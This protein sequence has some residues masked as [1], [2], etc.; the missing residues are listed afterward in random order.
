[1]ATVDYFRLEYNEQQGLFAHDAFSKR[2][3]NQFGWE[4]IAMVMCN[5]DIQLFIQS[6]QKIYPQVNTGQGDGFPKANT[7][8]KLYNDFIGISDL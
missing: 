3:E 6:V 4:T 7:I 1:M 8:R 5:D 2:K